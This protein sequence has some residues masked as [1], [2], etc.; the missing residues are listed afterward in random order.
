MK[1]ADLLRADIERSGLSANRYAVEVLKRDSRT[2]YRWLAGGKIPKTV[3]K[4]L[5]GARGAPTQERAED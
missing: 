3:V 5:L 4:Y 2:L 1:P